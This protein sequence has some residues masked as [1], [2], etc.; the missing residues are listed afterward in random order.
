[1]GD[2]MTRAVV[3]LALLAATGCA[4]WT[5]AGVPL[6]ERRADLRACWTQAAAIGVA[7]GP[8]V[9]GA[10]LTFGN[11]ITRESL[12]QQCMRERGYVRAGF[13]W[14]RYGR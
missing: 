12:F 13:T 6:E 9:T 2:A 3:V 5:H 4:R 1:M 14:D 11:E 7:G 10:L 8:G